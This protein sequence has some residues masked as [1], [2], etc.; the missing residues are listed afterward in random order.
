MSDQ[1]LDFRRSMQVVRRHKV[2]VGIFAAIG[3]AAG[4]AFSAMSP[5]QVKAEAEVALP[6]SVHDGATQDVIAKSYRVLQPA[7]PEI[8]PAMTDQKLQAAL[9]VTNPASNIMMITVKAPTAGQAKSAANAVANSF[10]SYIPSES[11]GKTKITANVVQPAI[12]V[13]G[14]SRYVE[15]AI[16]G[17]SGGLLLAIIAAIGVL[18][19][20][21][22]DRKLRT[23]D[24]IANSIGIPVLA[25]IAASHPADPAGWARLLAEYEP[26]P[27]HAW[28]MRSALRQLGLWG[29][30]P[31]DPGAGRR[32]SVAVLS[33]DTDPA[34]LALGPQ[35]A[36]F[37][38]SLGIRTALVLGPQQNPNLTA[39]L[40]TACNLQPS[41]PSRWSG[42]LDVIVCDTDDTQA[43]PK[44]AL[45]VVVAV[46][47]GSDPQAA[48]TM[49]ATTTILG[50]SAGVVTAEE[51]ARVAVSA[52]GDNRQITGI[53]VA[54]PDSEDHTTGRLPQAAPVRPAP[55]TIAPVTKITTE[56]SR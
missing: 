7:L 16:Y 46:V 39:T 45:T 28:G 42:Y 38:A 4:V 24:E 50:V 44:A 32:T 23:R 30:D 29:V 48:R 13:N 6:Q 8:H 56:T 55:R 47:S 43:L 34:A 12:E 33:V 17:L 40:R 31:A 20:S 15:Y 14:T 54:N 26:G 10:V 1:P 53:L 36:V 27:V 22:R 52:A 49:R 5:V 9:S 37:S 11:Q 25:S 19:A 41:T 18:A 35:L 2:F 51:L 3:V 21:R